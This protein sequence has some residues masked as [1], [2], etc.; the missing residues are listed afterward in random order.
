MFWMEKLQICAFQGL[1]MKRR[2]RDREGFYKIIMV[3]FLVLLF[4]W[5][6]FEG[7]VI[8]IPAGKTYGDW[9]VMLIFFVL[10]I[11]PSA[12]GLYVI[13]GRLL[14]GTPLIAYRQYTTCTFEGLGNKREAYLG[15][16]AEAVVKNNIKVI[17]KINF[18][19]VEG[20]VIGGADLLFEP[21]SKLVATGVRAVPVNGD[22][23]VGYSTP[24]RGKG[25]WI[26]FFMFTFLAFLAMYVL[27][28]GRGWGKFG[29]LIAISIFLAIMLSPIAFIVVYRKVYNRKIKHLLIQT[30]ESM[31][32]KQT[33]AFQKTTGKLESY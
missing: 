22:L 23:R 11:I 30:A 19:W 25:Y 6:I 21:P 12:A 14:K 26:S 2:L 7:V 28:W 20:I 9:A 29:D 24:P 1:D 5:G 32:G 17:E 33:T 16:L 13:Y 15:R 10:V 18:S 8:A 4:I 31:G 27:G 3:L